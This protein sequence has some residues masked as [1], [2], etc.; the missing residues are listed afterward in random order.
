MTDRLRTYMTFPALAATRLPD[1]R[2]VVRGVEPRG[3]NEVL[4]AAWGRF[5]GVAP[6]PVAEA[7]AS[8]Y[9]GGGNGE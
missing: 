5:C 9:H 8:G 7:E 4:R 2:V 3:P 1:G 6:V